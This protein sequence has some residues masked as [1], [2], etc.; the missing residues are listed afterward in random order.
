MFWE[1]FT[2]PIS[3]VRWFVEVHFGYLFLHK[4]QNRNVI[5]WLFTYANMQAYHINLTFHLKFIYI[6]YDVYS[7]WL[8]YMHPWKW[9][10]NLE[11]IVNPLY[12]I[13][14]PM[15]LKK[16]DLWWSCYSTKLFNFFGS[17]CFLQKYT[18]FMNFLWIVEEIYTNFV[19]IAI[20]L[21]WAISSNIS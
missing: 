19:N 2:L 1:F 13:A 12:T 15:L 9:L 4:H 11:T 6:T 14:V 16:Y 3:I 5:T 7:N 17:Y 20:E 10:Y 8:C 21:T 18:I